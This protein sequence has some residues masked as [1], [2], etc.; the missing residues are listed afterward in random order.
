MSVPLCL[1]SSSNWI[2]FLNEGGRETC[3]THLF[4]LDGV[5][6]LGQSAGT[7]V[8]LQDEDESTRAMRSLFIVFLLAC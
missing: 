1:H 6:N 5:F 2:V 7:Y 8:E 3:C 4:F